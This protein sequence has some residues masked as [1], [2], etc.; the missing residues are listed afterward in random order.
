MLGI[1]AP[2]VSR[3][4]PGGGPL[5]G[6][7]IVCPT[8]HVA[9]TTHG[10]HLMPAL[11]EL[12][13]LLPDAVVAGSHSSV[14][15]G[16]ATHDSREATPG[17][18]FVALVG[19]VSDGHD[20]VGSAV[21]NGAVAALV[22]RPV[23]VDI[24]QVVVPDTRLAAGPAAAWVHGQPSDD[25]QIV[26]TTGTN[27]KTTISWMIESAAAAAGQGTGMV[28][29]VATRINGA[30][31]SAV[32]TT[33]EGPDLQRLLGTMR[34]R[35][36]QVVAM[37]VSSHGLQLHRVDGTRFA[38]AVFTN[39][40]QDHLD[41]HATFDD[42]FAAKARLF[43]PE[44][45]DRAVIGV[46]DDWGRRLAGMTTLDHV[47]IGEDDAADISLTTVHAD[48]RG[49]RGVLAGPA[50]W[51]GGASTVEVETPLQGH[52]NLRNAAQAWVAAVS[53]GLDPA[54]VCA[55]IAAADDVPGRFEVVI[56]E[57]ITAIV[58]YAHSPDA[59][60]SLV[61]ALR[62]VTD[63][64]IILVLGAGGDR[65]RAKRG[66]MGA[67]AT[68]AEVVLFTSDNP[69]SEDPDDIIRDLIDGA[70]AAGSPHGRTHMEA[71]PDR[72]AAI[73]RGLA[74]AE[75]GDVVAV[76]GKGHETGQEVGG[77]TRP[78]DDREVVARRWAQDGG[79]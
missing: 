57:K 4:Q 58:D 12:V 20:H 17:S 31:Q 44:F 39:L 61:D 34:D 79:R 64:R 69:R 60:E 23:D 2:L 48:I 71:I 22:S 76:L 25:L 54:G 24:P 37:E 3:C 18:L 75:A 41:F 49:S 73:A 11:A 29:T 42:Y 26:G 15:V 13:T 1:G 8:D 16:D 38:T 5:V 32:R 52:F 53:L 33:P 36:A 51:L 65:D 62:P 70:M 50:E 47:T 30:Q 66:P 63:G 72:E 14:S 10:H 43:T 7:P 40:S 21:G 45:S 68:A 77:I 59:I 74:M 56:A 28:G 27:G 55:G 19:A 9:P 6:A 46:F 78:F 67:A 35:G